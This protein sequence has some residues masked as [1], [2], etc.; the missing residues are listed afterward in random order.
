MVFFGEVVSDGEQHH[1]TTKWHST[2]FIKKT[3]MYVCACHLNRLD[4]SI[5]IN[6]QIHCVDKLKV[7]RFGHAR[8]RIGFMRDLGARGVKIK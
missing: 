1:S 6:L 4:L 2:F 3:L 7:R 5:P 8:P